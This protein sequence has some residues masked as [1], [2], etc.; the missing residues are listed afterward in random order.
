MFSRLTTVLQYLVIWGKLLLNNIQKQHISLL[1]CI[2]ICTFLGCVAYLLRSADQ[3]T[4]TSLTSTPTV[5][6]V[7]P[8]KSVR[9]R[10]DLDEC[11]THGA[12]VDMQIGRWPHRCVL[13]DNLE[14]LKDV[15]F[16]LIFKISSLKKWRCPKKK[17]KVIRELFLITKSMII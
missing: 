10:S 2:S 3:K 7:R 13:N 16:L 11:A 6:C 15:V 17:I 5:R 8:S 9:D 4:P 12:N 1:R 14:P